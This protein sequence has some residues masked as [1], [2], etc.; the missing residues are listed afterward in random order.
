LRTGPFWTHLRTPIRGLVDEIATLYEGHPISASEAFADFHVSIAPPIS[1][2]RWFR[3]KAQ[4]LADG[5]EPF[6]PLPFDQ[7]LPMFE[8]GLNWC[9]A[10]YVNHFLIV[11]AAVIARGGR[12]V[13]MPGAP[14]SGKSTLAAGLVNRGW[15]LLSDELTLISLEDGSSIF[16]LAR[17]VSL[18]NESIEVMRRFAPSATLS[19]VVHDTAKGSVALLKPPAESIAQ[20][21]EPA[22]PAWIVFPKYLSGLPALLEPKPKAAIMIE[23]AKNAFNYSTHGARGFAIL[24]D[25]VDSCACYKF[26]YAGLDEAVEIFDRLESR[27]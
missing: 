23:M 26:T 9:V 8:W 16:G 20:V 13:I 3:P 24:A 1:L 19:R 14:G 4:F 5:I 10:T 21:A 2:R 27:H 18:K 15:R 12:A 7:A 6:H 17:P 11:H 22:R 25:I